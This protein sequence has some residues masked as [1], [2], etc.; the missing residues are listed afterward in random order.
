MGRTSQLTDGEVDLLVFLLTGWV[1]ATRTQDC[2][3]E[4]MGDL[5]Q[6]AR[7]QYLR[8]QRKN[9]QRLVVLAEDWNNL[10]TMALGAGFPPD[11]L[12]PELAAG[13]ATATAAMQAA[14]SFIRK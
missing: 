8:K 1:P 3:A 6:I 13:A 10:V 14:Q 7:D 11:Q 4:T 2:G 5:R 9:P 12:S